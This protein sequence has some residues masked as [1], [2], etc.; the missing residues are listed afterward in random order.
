MTVEQV[1]PS[2]RK[3]GVKNL[4]YRGPEDFGALEQQ[5]SVKSYSASH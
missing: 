5:I 3:T 1:L 4:D 2:S